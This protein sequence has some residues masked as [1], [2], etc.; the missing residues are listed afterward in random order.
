M[1]TPVNPGNFQVF[2]WAC[3]VHNAYTN[4]S[5]QLPSFFW[6][7]DAHNAYTCKSWELP[8]FYLVSSLASIKGKLLFCDVKSSEIYMWLYTKIP[9][10]G[11]VIL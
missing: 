6:A 8:I 11:K 10:L 4:K 2:I 3:E 5:W 1:L 7:C 9:L